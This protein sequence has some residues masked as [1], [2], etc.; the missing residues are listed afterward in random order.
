MINFYIILF[1]NNTH[2]CYFYKYMYMIN[3]DTKPDIKTKNL[4]V[5]IL[6]YKKLIQ[7]LEQ[8]LRVEKNTNRIL[9]STIEKMKRDKLWD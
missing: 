7:D 2:Y 6:L 5:Q 9:T 1:I 4:Q 8:K 3:R